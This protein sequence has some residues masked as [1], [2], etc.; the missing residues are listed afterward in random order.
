MILNTFEMV[1]KNKL[2]EGILSILK[3]ADI[4]AD[5]EIVKK[6]VDAKVIR[7]G[8]SMMVNTHGITLGIKHPWK[9]RTQSKSH[10]IQ[11]VVD[12]FWR[13][14]DRFAKKTAKNSKGF[15]LRSSPKFALRCELRIIAMLCVI[16][17]AITFTI[18][19]TL[20]SLD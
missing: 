17:F 6:T 12:F 4:S 11:D 20:A 10:R 19:F 9:G 5:Y 3:G 15:A 8:E 13:T 1:L 2:I 7:L 16:I 18:I 14:F